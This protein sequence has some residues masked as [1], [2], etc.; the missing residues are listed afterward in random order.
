MSTIDDR[1]RELLIRTAR[2]EGDRV[3]LSV[4][5]AG[6]G[7]EPQTADQLFQPFHTTKPDGMGIG[8]SISRSIIE[9]HEGR[10]WA[11][12]NVG[13][14]ATFSFSVPSGPVPPAKL[15]FAISFLSNGN[16]LRWMPEVRQILRDEFP[17]VEVTT[18]SQYSPC[19]AEALS[20][21]EI[22]ELCFEGKKGGQI[23]HMRLFRASA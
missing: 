5:D 9:A 11:A 1:P 12:P 10:L 7:L 4:K 19:L 21:G 23:W 20:K 18:S 16:E 2:E 14:G 13:P 8:L 15:G 22:D 6:V 17:N 3:C